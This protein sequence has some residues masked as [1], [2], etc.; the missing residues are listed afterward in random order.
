[1]PYIWVLEALDLTQM[2]MD[3]QKQLNRTY[4][5]ILNNFSFKN[6]TKSHSLGHPGVNALLL[7]VRGSGLHPDGHGHQETT[8]NNYSNH[9][10]QILF[11]QHAKKSFPGTP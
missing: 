9:T 3:I 1:M 2:V 5:I 4:S 6:I 8:Y 11:Q 10:Q 7:G